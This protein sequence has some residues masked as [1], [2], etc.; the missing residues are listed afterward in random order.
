[1][2]TLGAYTVERLLYLVWNW[3]FFQHQPLADILLAFLHGLRF[4]LSAVAILSAIPFLISAV[5]SM[6]KP[7][8]E[9]ASVTRYSLAALFLIFQTP[10]ML[11]NLGDT[12]FVSFLGRRYTFDALFFMREVPGKFWSLA[13]FYWFLATIIFAIYVLYATALFLAANYWKP[14]PIVNARWRR[15]VNCFVALIALAIASRGGLQN[16]P[17]NF[18]HAQVFLNPAMNNLVLNSSFTFIQTIRR[19]SLPRDLY[20]KETEEMLAELRKGIAEHS[21][22]NEPSF[23]RPEQKPNIVLIIMESFALEYMGKPHG[24]Q[25]YTPFLDELAEKSLFFTNTFANARRSIEGI[26]AIMGGVPA[27]MNEPFIS[28]QYLTNYYL[29]LGSLLQEQGYR[30]AFFHGAENGSMYFDQFMKAAGVKEYYGKSQYPRPEETDGTWGIWDEPFLQWM[31]GKLGEFETPFFA[32]VFSLTSHNPFPIPKE[33]AGKFP[34]GTLDIH[35]VIGY[36]D[37]ALKKFFESASKE[38][39][40]QN[41]VFIITADHTYKIGRKEYDNDLGHYRVPLLIYSPSIQWPK[42]DTTQV[43]QHVDLMP[44]ILDIA[45]SEEKERNYLGNSVFQ[46]GDRYA[47]TLSD[48]TYLM[49]AKDYYLRYRRGGQYEMFSMLPGNEGPLQEPAERKAALEMR[50]K[51]VLQYFSQGLWDNKLYYPTR[52]E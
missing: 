40:F 52:F 20:F 41:T 48:G 37:Y 19:E 13:S 25:G 51:A 10:T 4:D 23:K 6:W 42:I 14:N 16:K 32:S 3:N 44:T 18:A 30:T 43:V 5:I 50:M 36:S 29:G 2:I 45:G 33:Y 47:V 22:L 26:G 39:W 7:R 12:E 21:L 31:N 11:L 1:M 27:L 9:N 15:A 17:I 34:K 38:K 35:E 46:P 24:G 49:I 8:W 28:S